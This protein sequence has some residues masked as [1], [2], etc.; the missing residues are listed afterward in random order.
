VLYFTV[1]YSH[2][3][4]ATAVQTVP[5]SGSLCQPLISAESGQTGRGHAPLWWRM[6][7]L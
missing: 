4:C 6:V 3:T 5:L 2:I 7:C 1:T